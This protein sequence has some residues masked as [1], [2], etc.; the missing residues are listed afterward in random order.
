MLGRH[1]HD[2]GEAIMAGAATV[3]EIPSPPHQGHT[4]H[5]PVVGLEIYDLGQKNFL[6]VFY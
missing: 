3:L 4:F 1:W 5:Q 6:K 2:A